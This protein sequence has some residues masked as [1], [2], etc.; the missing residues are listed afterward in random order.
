MRFIELEEGFGLGIET[1]SD[2]GIANDFGFEAFDCNLAAEPVV[3]G[4]PDF[5]EGTTNEDPLQFVLSDS[6]SLHMCASLGLSTMERSF[7]PII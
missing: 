2:I 4:E 3:V 1:P 6:S 5:A 7:G